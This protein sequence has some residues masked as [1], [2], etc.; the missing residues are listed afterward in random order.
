MKPGDRVRTNEN[1]PLPKQFTGV[2][3]EYYGDNFARVAQGDEEYLF[4]LA[5]LEKA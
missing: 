4:P 5:E 3:I 2:F 1:Y